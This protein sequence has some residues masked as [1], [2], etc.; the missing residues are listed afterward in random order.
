MHSARAPFGRLLR[1]GRQRAGLA[2]LTLA[3]HPQ[4]L[5]SMIEPLPAWREH[6]LARLARQAMAR[7]DATLHTLHTE[8]AARPAPANTQAGAAA[9]LADGAEADHVAHGQ[10]EEVDAVHG[11]R[12]LHPCSLWHDGGEAPP[13]RP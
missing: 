7:G 12:P 3:L 6:V 4:G 2:Q 1:Q 13:R 10:R 11:G 9:P 5:A 8:L